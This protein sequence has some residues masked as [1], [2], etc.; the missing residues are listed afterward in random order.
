MGSLVVLVAY[1]ARG[2]SHP[3][4]QLVSLVATLYTPPIFIFSQPGRVFAVARWAGA[5][6]YLFYAACNAA[7][8][9]VLASWL[10][11]LRDRNLLIRGAPVVAV[12]LGATRSPRFAP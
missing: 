9:A 10:Y 2:L 12:Q 6:E 4:A 8:Y 5:P 3:F 11:R 1:V 7:I